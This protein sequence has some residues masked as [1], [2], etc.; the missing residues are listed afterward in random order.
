MKNVIEFVE[1]TDPVCT[2]CWGSE[3]LLRALET[4]FG[5]QIKISFVMGGL[6]PD[7]RNFSDSSNGIGGSAS[8]S[9]R[10]II[11]HWI[12]ASER[13]G[14]PVQE[15]GFA[16]FSDEFPSTF[17]QNIAYKAAQMEDEAKANRFL[18]RMREASAA[19]ARQI[20]RPEVLIELASESGLDLGAFL[21]RLSDGS[22]QKAFEADL[23]LTRSSRVH[24]FPT[25]MIRYNGKEIL[26]RGF[27]SLNSVVAVIH[28]LTGDAIREQIPMQDESHVL[29]FLVKHGKAAPAEIVLSFGFKKA[30][31]DSLLDKLVTDK[32]VVKIPAGN[33][34]FLSPVENSLACDA[35]SGICSI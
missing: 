35:D 8:E 14:M 23:A 22:A 34:Y 3:P 19:E 2:W 24:G 11:R 21:D 32:K 29:E 26:L 27:Q 5:D 7:I 18:R 15:E 28:S 31:L 20:S 17:P 4:R 33:G 9:N 16:L 1:F 12:E 25:F 6:V 13:H 30:V 10:Q